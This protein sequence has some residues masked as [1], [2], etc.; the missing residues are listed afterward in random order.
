MQSAGGLWLALTL[1][2]NHLPAAAAW[3]MVQPMHPGARRDARVSMGLF[4]SLSK[5]FANEEFKEDDQRVRASHILKKGEDDFDQIVEIMGELSQRVEKDPERL[6]AIFA[7]LARRESECS[8]KAQGGDL[9]LFGP[10]KMVGEFDDVLFPEDADAA[11]PPGAVLGPVVTDFGTHR[12]L[13]TCDS[14]HCHAPHASRRPCLTTA[15]F[16]HPRGSHTRHQARGQPRSGRGE[17][18]TQRLSAR[19][20]VHSRLGARASGEALTL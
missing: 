17:A 7:E 19:G 9:G 6:Y 18:R 5:A 13:R 15:R 20:R 11:P 8:S 14:A 1:A 2:V 3:R 12:V 4:D 16:T 10:G